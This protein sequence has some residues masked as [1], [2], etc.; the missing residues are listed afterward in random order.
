MAMTDADQQAYMVNAIWDE[1]ARVWVATSDDVP[2]LV[3]EA[4]NLDELRAN[5]LDIIPVLLEENG[6]AVQRRSD[7]VH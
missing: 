1:D 6:E 3:T 5:L 2:G 4:E 7:R